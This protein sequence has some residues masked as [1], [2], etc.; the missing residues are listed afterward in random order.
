MYQRLSKLFII[1]WIKTFSSRESDRWE[2]TLLSQL[3]TNHS[4]LKFFFLNTRETILF[5]V[6]IHRGKAVLTYP[7]HIISFYLYI[8]YIFTKC[9]R[10]FFTIINFSKIFVRFID[11]LI[12]FYN[13]NISLSFLNRI[14][15]FINNIL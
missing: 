5:S 1:H 8:L 12:H 2:I 6:K 10:H 4:C 7:L 9:G 11:S 13:Q 3:N 14:R 15:V